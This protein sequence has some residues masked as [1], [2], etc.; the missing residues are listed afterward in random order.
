MFIILFQGAEE[1]QKRLTDGQESSSGAERGSQNEIEETQ[2][3]PD[4]PAHSA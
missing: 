3:F 2:Q 1:T 4:S